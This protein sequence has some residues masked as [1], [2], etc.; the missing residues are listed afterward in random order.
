MTSNTVVISP[1]A[2]DLEAALRTFETTTKIALHPVVRETLGRSDQGPFRVPFFASHGSYLFGSFFAPT[3]AM[4]GK[5]DLMRISC[6]TSLDTSLILVASES[7]NTGVSDSFAATVRTGVHSADSCA[8]SILAVLEAVFNQLATH[9][10][11][12]AD[13][14]V[15]AADGIEKSSRLSS[16]R[17]AA[18]LA[19][20][21]TKLRVAAGELVNVEPIIDALCDISS[22]I[23][24]DRLDLKGD[25]KGELFGKSSEIRSHHLADRYRQLM[26]SSHGASRSLAESQASY[27]A[28]VAELRVRGNQMLAALATLF[29]TPVILLNI[30][31][32]F[33]AEGQ[34]WSNEFTANY[35]WVVIAGAAAAEFAVFRAKKWLR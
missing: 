35:F 28:R 16:R 8:G 30:Y 34:S 15:A 14:L 4:D 26:A 10:E 23:A 2:H 11:T 32:Q 1:A 3:S 6:L 7:A 24:G 22:A 33:L 18:E 9:H 31:S 29:L 20:C 17:A 12:I 21:Q 5:P 19:T 13:E 27:Q 25:G